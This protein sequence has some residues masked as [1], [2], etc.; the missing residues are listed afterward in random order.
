MLNQST[1]SIPTAKDEIAC[2][3]LKQILKDITL[4][5]GGA[6]YAY[7]V[8]D[9]AVWEIARSLDRIFRKALKSLGDERARDVEYSHNSQGRKHPAI[10]E[11]LRRLDG[12]EKPSDE[13]GQNGKLNQSAAAQSS[14]A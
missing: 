10:V 3:D 8:P 9:E 2:V 11:L 14:L 7:P 5:L 1:A 12:Y 13:D 6:F 4:A